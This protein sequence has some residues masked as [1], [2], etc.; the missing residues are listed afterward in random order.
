MNWPKS[1]KVIDVT[2]RDGLQDATGELTSEQKIELCKDLYAAGVPSV[3]ITAFVSPKWVPL[4]RD[5]ETVANALRDQPDTIALVPNHKGFERA[6][7]TGVDA[8]TFVVSASPIHQ[9]ENL[10]M[11]L[12]DSFEQFRGIAQTHASSQIRLRGAISCAFGSP[13]STESI[14]PETVADIAREYVDSGAVELSLA[15]TVGVGTPQAIYD[16]ILLVKQRVGHDI[17]ITLH[18]HD[19]YALGLGNIVAALAAGVTVFETALAGLG[20]CPFVPD[21]PGNLDTEQVVHWL[22]LM[23]IHTG[24]DE[25]ALVHVRKRLLKDLDASMVKQGKLR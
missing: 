9:R 6:L 21:A 7:R 4:M 5:A 2:P 16:T 24:I 19:R 13:F 3:E 18:L 8:V 22:H 11:S 20:G 15:D 14:T 1:V 17:P 12:S 10:R 25:H 23:G